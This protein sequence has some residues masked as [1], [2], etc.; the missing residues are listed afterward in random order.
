MLPAVLSELRQ[1]EEYAFLRGNEDFE[2][3][4]KK[5]ETNGKQHG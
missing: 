2:R 4:M 3:L 1:S 5:W